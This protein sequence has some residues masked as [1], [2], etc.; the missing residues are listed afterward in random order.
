MIPL[1][2]SIIN[3]R[4]AEMTLRCARSALDDLAHDGIAGRV[5]IVDNASGDGSVERI[6]EWIRG[7][8]DGTPVELVRSES[9]SGFSGGHNRGMAAADADLYLLL[10]S[11]ALLRPGFCA[12]ILEAAAAHSRAGFLAPR[13][14]H[15]DGTRQV[16]AFRFASP[17]SEFARGA[18]TGWVDRMARRWKVALGDDADPAR[19]QW[20]SFACVALRGEMVREIGAMDEGYF[21]YF[22]DAEYC[23]RGRRAGWSI[24]RVPEAAAVH[25]RG[26]SGPVKTLH[27]ARRR[28][29]AYYYA[30][31]TRFLYQAHGRAGLWTA[32]A[33]WLMGRGLAQMR[34]LLGRRPNP[35]AEAE[36]RDIWTNAHRPLGPRRAPWEDGEAAQ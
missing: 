18:N 23:L 9:N 22:E 27:K 19:I 6:A 29:P 2:I 3:Y 24:A 5:V 33:A 34:R 13:I 36:L 25:F 7:Q 16:S 10:N 11:D 8:S 15:E 26:G 20:V 31:R 21:L 17:V 14:E 32:N 12:A 4:T 1:L 28:M 35:A 30:S